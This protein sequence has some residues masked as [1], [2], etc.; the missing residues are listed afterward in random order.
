MG[1]D[2]N[3]CFSFSPYKREQEKEAGGTQGRE[4]EK[5]RGESTGREI[6]RRKTTMVSYEIHPHTREQEHIG[7]ILAASRAHGGLSHVA[8]R[9]QGLESSAL[10]TLK[11]AS[12]DVLR[13]LALG[14]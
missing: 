9:W 4:E 5:G 7:P 10:F 12:V 1:E 14:S 2:P 11:I 6:H 13:A 8:R 3:I